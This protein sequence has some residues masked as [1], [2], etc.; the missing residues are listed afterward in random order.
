MFDKSPSLFNT[1]LSRECDLGLWPAD[2]SSYEKLHLL[3]K[4]D[5]RHVVH[6]LWW[7]TGADAVLALYG[8]LSTN[9]FCAV[10]LQGLSSWHQCKGA[11]CV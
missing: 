4:G 3:G 8:W 5:V 6:I 7:M 2:I 1:V 9:L 10:P 11:E